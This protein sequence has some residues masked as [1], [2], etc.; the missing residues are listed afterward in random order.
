VWARVFRD[1]A[2]QKLCFHQISGL[3]IA[4]WPIA[5]LRD[6]RRVEAAAQIAIDAGLVSEPFDGD[7]KSERRLVT[8]LWR[9][10][11]PNVD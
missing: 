1:Q 9:W 3:P 11:C 5:E 7:D 8:L 6:F 4:N 2:R 10:T